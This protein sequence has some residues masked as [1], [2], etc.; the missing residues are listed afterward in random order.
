MKKIDFLIDYLMEEMS[1]FENENYSFDNICD[2]K[3]LYRSLC[4]IREPRS[5]SEKYIEIENSFLKDE[6]KRKFIT[7][8]AN[9]EPVINYKNVD[10]CLW[11]GDITTLKIGAIVNAANSQGLGCF[12][13]CH[14]CIDNAIHSA[15]GV[16]L[17]LECKKKMMKIKELRT[18][19]AFLTDAYNLPSKHVIHTVGPIIYDVVSENKIHELKKC[20]ISSLNLAKDNGIREIAFCA[21]STGEYNFPKI[22]ASNIA[23]NTVKKYI[24]IDENARYFNKI[25]FNV[26]SDEDYNIYYKN[27]GG[28]YGGI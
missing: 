1:D 9:I 11:K 18:G 4:N 26:F 16:Q 12:I 25:I 17:R 28:I 22:V 10:I 15:S 8:S 24:E 13:P 27:L 23:I 20:Y 14:K 5:V 3:T 2:K 6:M 21:I 7:D 19:E